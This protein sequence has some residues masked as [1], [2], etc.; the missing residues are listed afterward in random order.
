MV[1]VTPR[2]SGVNLRLADGSIEPFDAAIL[3]CH[4]DQALALIDAPTP[5]ERSVLGA[6][7]YRRNDVYLHRD[8]SLMPPRR[9][10]WAGWNVIKD[11]QDNVSVTYW[12]NALQGV[13]ESRPLFVSLNPHRPPRP[14]LVF[15][16]Y[17]YA[18]PQFDQA[19]LEAQTRLSGLQGERHLWFCGAWTG[20]GFHEDGLLSGLTVAQDLGASL[21][22]GPTPRGFQEAAE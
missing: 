13:D 7:R 9:T 15:G 3:A 2:S 19:A 10:A 5:A 1:A 8:A 21:P 4:S 12:M 22:W 6:I 16:R 20:Y 17:D 18:H 14:D 11:A